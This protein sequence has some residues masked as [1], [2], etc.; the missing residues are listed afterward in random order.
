ML[1]EI[2]GGGLA[3]FDADGD[4]RLDIY[5]TN[6]GRWPEGGAK[7]RLFRRTDTGFVD[8]T[9]KSG[10]G[11]VGYGMGVACGDIDNDGDIDLYV[12]NDGDDILYRNEGDGRF[13]DHT[14]AAGI[15][16]T[17]WTSS[18]AFLDYDR[19]GFL[20]IWVVRYVDFDPTTECTN[21]RSQR[22]YCGPQV[23]RGIS[24]VL[25]RNRGDGTFEDV[26]RLAGVHA[27]SGRGLGVQ[28]DDFDGDGWIDVFVANDGEANN[29]WM[30][31]HDG[32]FE[33]AGMARGVALNA[34]GAAEASMG[35]AV[36]DIDEDG[37][38]DLF[39]THLARESNTLYRNDG[40]GRFMDDSAPS[41]L[42][43]SSL[44]FTGFGTVIEDLDNDGDLDVAVANG[45]VSRGGA[46]S[47]PGDL[48]SEMA[49]PNQLFF[50]RGKGK[51]DESEGGDFTND[52]ALGRCLAACDMN[53]DGRPDLVIGNCGGRFRLLENAIATAERHWLGV[54]VRNEKRR[55]LAI[56]A[57]IE[58][59]SGKRSWRRMVTTTGSYATSVV[60]PIHIGL[61]SAEHY[62]EIRVRWPDGTEETFDGGTVDRVITIARGAG[63]SS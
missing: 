49:E 1:P 21:T 11:Q 51:F 37:D 47:K 46:F 9:D 52:V 18:V 38:P 56:G 7:D 26:T 8:V 15:R 12:G 25:Y 35:V 10:L 30:N 63:R 58:V 5:C 54:I 31:Q 23:F 42:G 45:R 29:L 62:E 36:G 60:A 55:R 41:G 34:S 40:S 44:R 32:T 22:D 19:D 14:K 3:V 48:W 2:T 61:G 50:N 53:G 57:E 24:D 33:D 39:M 59:R 4:G 13:V 6:A 28:I 27:F 17:A 16:G 43:V 20:D